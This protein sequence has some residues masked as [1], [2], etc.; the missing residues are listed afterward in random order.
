M[1]YEPF[2]E[3]ARFGGEE[4]GASTVLQLTAPSSAASRERH[5]ARRA[6]AVAAERET[7]KA[8]PRRRIADFVTA[9]AKVTRNSAINVDKVLYSVSSR[10]IGHRIEVR[11]FDDQL[12][13]FLGPGPVMRVTRVR[14]D[15]AHGHAIDYHHLIGTLRSK[16]QALRTLVYRETPLSARRL[17]PRL[18]RLGRRPAAQRRLPDDGRIAGFGFDP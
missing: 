10:L 9:S 13:C 18:D 17:R 1:P 5:N 6:T 16:P 3:A 4:A 11:L 7:L 8:L 12:E 14:T 2:D 15:R